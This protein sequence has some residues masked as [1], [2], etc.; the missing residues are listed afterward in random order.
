LIVE[1][2]EKENKEEGRRKDHTHIPFVVGGKKKAGVYSVYFAGKRDGKK[3]KGGEKE[4][5]KTPSSTPM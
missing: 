3:G 1:K 2:T 4:N 5:R